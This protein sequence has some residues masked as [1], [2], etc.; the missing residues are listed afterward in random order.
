M[1]FR[2]CPLAAAGWGHLTKRS[3]AG[4]KG[5]QY[6]RAS[7]V[8]VDH[9]LNCLFLYIGGTA[10]NIDRCING[11]G[12]E[13]AGGWTLGSRSERHAGW[14]S[15]NGP[16]TVLS[17]LKGKLGDFFY[18]FKVFIGPKLREVSISNFYRKAPKLVKNQVK[19]SKID[20]IRTK[21]PTATVGIHSIQVNSYCRNPPI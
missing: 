9:G 16:Q 21:R 6:I 8:L 3:A 14:W 12:P 4:L 20:Q 10:V 2:C 15:R 1:I 7:Q 11:V 17:S 18:L 13:E 19:G 5:S